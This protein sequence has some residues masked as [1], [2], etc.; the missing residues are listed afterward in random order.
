MPAQTH[1]C[2]GVPPMMLHTLAHSWWARPG[3]THRPQ[4]LQHWK[5]S[6]RGG[7]E[8]LGHLLWKDR[9]S[10]EFEEQC[11]WVMG[12]IDAIALVPSPVGPSTPLQEVIEGK[13]RSLVVSNPDTLTLRPWLSPSGNRAVQV[14]AEWTGGTGPNK[15]GQPWHLPICYPGA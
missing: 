2:W 15:P 11:Q 4:N 13:V 12:Q 7:G 9:R 10:S 3:Y 8:L 5:H 1:G 6:K 14:V